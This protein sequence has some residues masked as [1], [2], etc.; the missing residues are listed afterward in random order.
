[1]KRNFNLIRKILLMTEML[2]SEERWDDF[3]EF[4]NDTRCSEQEALYQVAQLLED[5]MVNGYV[6]EF[7][8]GINAGWIDN[9]TTHGEEFLKR[10][11]HDSVW[12]KVQPLLLKKTGN[13]TKGL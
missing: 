13:I 10:I 8:D 5:G 2:K 12:K 7:V 9:I 1:M 6:V 4:A 3:V 11:R